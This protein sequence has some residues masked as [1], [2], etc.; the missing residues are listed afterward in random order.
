MVSD[1]IENEIRLQEKSNYYLR[2]GNMNRYRL[3]WKGA[4]MMTVKQVFPLKNILTFLD[5]QSARKA[6]AGMP[7][8][9]RD[10]GLWGQVFA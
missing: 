5:L 7:P 4:I 6:V 1:D 8:F 2:D 3:T 10:K 9:S